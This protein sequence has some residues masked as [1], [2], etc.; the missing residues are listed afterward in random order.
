MPTY[1]RQCPI[2]NKDINYTHLASFET[3]VKTNKP[4]VS[5]GKRKN[6]FSFEKVEL[7]KQMIADG[8]FTDEIKNILRATDAQYKYLISKFDLKSNKKTTIKIVD[9]ENKLAQCSECDRILPLEDN[10][11]FKVK[12]NGY[13]FYQTYCYDCHYKKRNNH[14]NSSL[15]VF[16]QERYSHI[17]Q[18]SKKKNII[19]SISKEDFIKQYNNQNGLCFYTDLPMICLYGHGKQRDAVS[20][21][22]IIPEKGYAK[23][24][25]V[26]CLN[27]INMAKH[28]FSLEE[29]Q[30]WMPDWYN[31][32][33]KFLGDVK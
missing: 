31:R 32:I 2:C 29:I 3:A 23:G 28:D 17:K 18:S 11:F 22:K 12:K 10:F 26:F 1:A 13:K 9:E 16:L 30:K 33:Q 5:C 6:G 25:V 21:D 27:R 7:F 8:Y 14:I 19:F 24:N 4:C 20:V 15:D